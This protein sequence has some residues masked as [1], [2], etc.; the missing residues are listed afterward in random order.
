MAYTSPRWV[1][2]NSPFLGAPLLQELTDQVEENQRI[3]A[4]TAPTTSTAGTLGQTRVNTATGYIYI[5][6]NA[7]PP[8]QWRCLSTA[9]Q[10]EKGTY[11]GT[12]TY[13]SANPTSLTFSIA[14]KIV[15][16]QRQSYA[17]Q[18][19]NV[20]VI[21]NSLAAKAGCINNT[22][23]SAESLSA[24]WTNSGKTLSWYHTNTGSASAAAMQLNYNGVVYQYIAIG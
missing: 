9:A 1:N 24:T 14:P 18:Y 10:G 4:T 17:G 11:T 6:V 13:G 12:G 19:G 2:G 8:Y 23:G 22:G 20:P 21:F 7:S 15:I 16:I 3:Y 5:C